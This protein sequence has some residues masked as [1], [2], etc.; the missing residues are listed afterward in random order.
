MA[1]K[2]IVSPRAAKDLEKITG[3][4][5]ENWNSKVVEGFINRYEECLDF[6]SEKPEFYPIA[7]KDKQ[8]RR[9]VMTKHNIIYFKELSDR[10]AILTVFDTRQN[11]KKL[12][13][14]L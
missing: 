4:L 10:I 9:C 14:I 1:K 11:P 7:R 6:I 8:I 5:F 2:V 13:K 3:Y 12:N